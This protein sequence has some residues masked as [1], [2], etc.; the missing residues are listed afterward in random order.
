MSDWVIPA[1]RLVIP[2]DRAT[3]RALTNRDVE[4]SVEAA[5]DAGVRAA[6]EAGEP[7]LSAASAA[8]SASLLPL[9]RLSGGEFDIGPRS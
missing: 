8:A 2:A 4:E 3:S 6:E 5:E 9:P 1:T 7:P